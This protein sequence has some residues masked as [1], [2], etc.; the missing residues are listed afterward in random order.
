MMGSSTSFH[1]YGAGVQRGEEI[2]QLF[3]VELLA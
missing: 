2:N 1:Q 3:A